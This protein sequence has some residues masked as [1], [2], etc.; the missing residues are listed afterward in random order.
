MMKNFKD[1]IFGIVSISFGCLLLIFLGIFAYFHGFP[2]VDISADM[3]HIYAKMPTLEEAVADGFINVSELQYGENSTIN[4]FFTAASEKDRPNN[5]LATVTE[6]NG[7]V[8]LHRYRVLD[9]IDNTA[10]LLV[11][12]KE[13]EKFGLK[14]KGPY[15]ATLFR[16]I[17]KES[18]DG[19]KVTSKR[20]FESTLTG[21]DGPFFNVYL[22]PVEQRS[23]G[24]F[25][26]TGEKELLYT[27]R[28]V[29][30]LDFKFSKINVEDNP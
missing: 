21:I 3:A 5:F 10:L 11:H 7:K 26:L 13:S 2:K 4:E 23:K 8:V 24:N 27:Y 9:S 30:K 12:T 25:V 20:Y 18:F 28:N 29:L 22:Y 1:I 6:E 15:T 19:E 17:L 14:V 16:I